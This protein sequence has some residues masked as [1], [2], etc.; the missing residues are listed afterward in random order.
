[1]SNKD[2]KPM[3][4]GTRL[5]RPIVGSYDTSYEHSLEHYIAVRRMAED[6]ELGRVAVSGIYRDGG[7]V[8]HTVN[9]LCEAGFRNT[10]ISVLF[11]RGTASGAASGGEVSGS[12]GWLVGIGPV[13]AAAVG[14]FI[15]VGPIVAPLATAGAG[16]ILDGLLGTLF[17]IGIQEWDAKRYQGRVKEGGIL[18]SVYVDSSDARA[19][20]ILE[21]TG[22]DD[23]STTEEE[24]AE[25][26][27]SD[28]PLPRAS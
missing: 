4:A 19:K 24:R 22:A 2:S 10:D 9:A 11:E 14:Q 5:S 17:G 23:I 28:N 26:Q 13:A 27:R 21:R 7:A 20:H 8:N 25:W 1:M 6:A 12:L 18:L 3:A 15:A 16:G